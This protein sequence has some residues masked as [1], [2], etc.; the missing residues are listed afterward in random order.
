MR[1]PEPSNSEQA[2]IDNVIKYTLRILS[3]FS[4]VHVK[5]SYHIVLYCGFWNWGKISTA[6]LCVVFEI[7]M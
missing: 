7:N 3:L 5:M 2:Y 4:V 1:V 6:H